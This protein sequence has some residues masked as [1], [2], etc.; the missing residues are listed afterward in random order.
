M[1]KIV[2]EMRADRNQ[3]FQPDFLHKCYFWS[4]KSE[5]EEWICGRTKWGH[6]TSDVMRAKNAKITVFPRAVVVGLIE[7]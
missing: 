7:P 4:I 6:A 1:H 3:S 5:I 2:D